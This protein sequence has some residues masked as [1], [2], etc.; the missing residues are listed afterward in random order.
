MTEFSN[1]TAFE[2]F[3]RTQLEPLRRALEQMGPTARKHFIGGLRI[4]SAEVGSRSDDR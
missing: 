2:A 4:L 1:P 3:A